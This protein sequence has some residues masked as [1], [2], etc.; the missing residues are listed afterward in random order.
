MVTISLPLPRRRES[1]FGINPCNWYPTKNLQVGSV[2]N[3]LVG[4]GTLR[5]VLCLLCL[6]RVIGLFTFDKS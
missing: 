4:M 3:M 2:K 1:N 5:H 6:L